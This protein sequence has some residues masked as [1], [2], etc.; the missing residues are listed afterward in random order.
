MIVVIFFT[1]LKVITLGGNYN[2][3]M[4]GFH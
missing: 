1:K 2:I 4:T 3:I